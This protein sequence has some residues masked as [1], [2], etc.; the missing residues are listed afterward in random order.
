MS[1]SINIE[2][3]LHRINSQEIK[4]NSIFSVNNA[5][6]TTQVN[7]LLPPSKSQMNIKPAY[8]ENDKLF[9]INETKK[10]FNLSPDSKKLLSTLEL[11][12][13]QRIHLI[14]YFT[15]IIL[16]LL[17]YLIIIL[18]MHSYSKI[19]IDG[20]QSNDNY[21][22]VFFIFYRSIAQTIISSIIIKYNKIYIPKFK[23]LKGKK[24]IFIR[25]LSYY[26][27]LL[28]LG[29]ML[30]YL[31]FVT[32]LSFNIAIYPCIIALV[33]M[34]VY[35]ENINIRQLIYFITF[36]V[37]ISCL[38]NNEIKTRV[39][40]PDQNYYINSDHITAIKTYFLNT[41]TLDIPI[42]LC[43]AIFHNYFFTLFLVFEDKV[44]KLNPSIHPLHL[45]HDLQ[46]F[47]NS[48]IGI[49]LSLFYLLYYYKYW[50]IFLN[51]W[52]MCGAVA[53]GV[54]IYLSIILSRVEEGK[55][56]EKGVLF[57]NLFGG[58]L[59]GI[60]LSVLLLKEK[61]NQID[62]I[63]A[64]LVHLVNIGYLLFSES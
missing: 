61:F 50:L 7:Q 57:C 47:L 28:F 27:S 31:R 5:I 54:L 23:E 48:I 63:G 24:W 1:D 58:H 43:F 52:F 11:V 30:K 2:K 46:L 16:Y 64:F 33:R 22:I 40:S 53:N 34:I 25:A 56:N 36:L 29:K 13:L 15:S 9:V 37:G 38:I 42:G 45:D 21:H 51:G 35:T 20:Y 59:I 18:Q 26:I 60:G 19:T 3:L 14:R 8:S 6:T 39:I 62:F 55:I 41:P 12:K 4:K 49:L 44:N 10:S 32:F 17:S